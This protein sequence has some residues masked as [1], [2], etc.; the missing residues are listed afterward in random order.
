MIRSMTGYAAAT[1]ELP[2][3]MLALE[4]RSVN[5]RFL[6]ISFRVADELRAGEAAFREAIVAGVGRGKIDCRLAFN[7]RTLGRGE[8]HLDVGVLASLARLQREI[9]AVIPDAQPL[10]VSEVLHW[11]GVFGDDPDAGE[12]LREAAVSLVRD[13]V[14]ELDASRVREGDKLA[15]MIRSRVAKIRERL[16]ALEPAIP[17]AIA[18]YEEKLAAKLRE[19]LGGGDEERIRQ[20]IAVFG[21]KVDVAEEFSRLATHLDEVDRTVDAG[22]AVGK[23]L[24]FLMQELNRETNTLGSKS[25]SREVSQAVL[26]FKLLI[27]QMREQVQNLE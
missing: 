11:P 2:Q 9:L 5:S 17:Q 10:R 8:A 12:A 7:A 24:D 13:A 21:V 22:G 14:V 23:R 20:E 15:R 4:L 3:G 19:A 25:V 26:E 27:E 16:K 6:D 1:R 18:A